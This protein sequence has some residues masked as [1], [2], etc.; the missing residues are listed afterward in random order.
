MNQRNSVLESRSTRM[1]GRRARLVKDEEVT[2][3]MSVLQSLLEACT[4]ILTSIQPMASRYRRLNEWSRFD[5]ER[6]LADIRVGCDFHPL[7]SLARSTSEGEHYQQRDERSDLF[8]ERPKSSRG[9]SLSF[10]KRFGC[11]LREG[12]ARKLGSFDHL[13]D[14]MEG[15][16]DFNR[17]KVVVL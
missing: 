9:C 17:I 13:M 1:I 8:E 7:C 5:P 12:I 11:V 14:R 10:R 3:F 2:V 15:V 4:N 6:C 16:E